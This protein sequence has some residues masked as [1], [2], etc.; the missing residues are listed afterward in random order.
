[1]EKIR[2]LGILGIYCGLIF[3][4][5]SL[6][7]IPLDKTF[8]YED[9]VLHLLA[10]AIMALLAWRSFRHFI[11]DLPL[12]AICCIGFC[13]LYGVS[14]EIHQYYVPGR[15]SSVTDVAADLIGALLSVLLICF[16]R[17][18]AMVRE[19]TDQ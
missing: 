16:S 17:R 15:T 19:R 6:P 4:L 11:Q 10:Y 1:L 12:L 3:F 14:D 2:D 8:E 9:K 5:S 13:G 7:R 18:T